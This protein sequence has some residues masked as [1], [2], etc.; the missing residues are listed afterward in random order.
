[1]GP[2]PCPANEMKLSAFELREISRQWFGHVA[3]ID[4]G[5]N[6]AEFKF[7]QADRFIIKLFKHI[8]E[9]ETENKALRA[10]LQEKK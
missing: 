10:K 6:P 1:M 2:Q 4:P 7:K 9:L 8:H 5:T 3:Y